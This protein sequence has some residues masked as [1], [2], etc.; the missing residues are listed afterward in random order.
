MKF[1]QVKFRAKVKGGATFEVMVEQNRG[2]ILIGG[3]VVDPG[4]LTG[5]LRFVLTGGSPRFYTTYG[6]ARKKAETDA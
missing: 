1:E 6:E 5:K 2:N 4:P 3:R